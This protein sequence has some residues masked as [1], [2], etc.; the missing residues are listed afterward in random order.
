MKM[1]DYVRD[2]QDHH[3]SLLVDQYQPCDNNP[4]T[5]RQSLRTWW[6]V[7]MVRLRFWIPLGYRYWSRKSWTANPVDPTYVVRWRFVLKKLDITLLSSWG[8]EA[9]VRI[10]GRLRHSY[11][12]RWAKWMFGL[13]KDRWTFEESRYE[14]DPM[15]RLSDYE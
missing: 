3:Q 7:F 6:S 15:G 8:V 11:D 5:T 9:E 12:A 2:L 13:L 4:I 1:R 10:F 14:Q